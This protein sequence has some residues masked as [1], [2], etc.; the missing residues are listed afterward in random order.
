MRYLLFVLLVLTLLVRAR[1]QA[2]DAEKLFRAMEQKITQARAFQVAVVIETGRDTDRPGS[3]KGFLLLTRDN[4][5]RL[6]VSGA[7]FGEARV[8]QMVSNGKQMKL[9]PYD[10]GVSEVAKK[11]ATLPTPKD[12]HDHLARSVSRLGVFPHLPR[13]PVMLMSDDALQKLAVR[14]F[15]AGPAEKVGG[16]DA[17]VVRFK[18]GPAELKDQ[19]AITVW[20]D[21]KMLLPLKRVINL[22]PGWGGAITETYPTFTLDPRPDAGAFDPTFP[23]SEAEKLFRAMD[24]KIKRANAIRAAVRIEVKAGGKGAKGR[25]SLLFTKDNQ[26]RFQLEIDAPD[27]KEAAEMISDGKR[28]K[29]AKLPDPI[30]KAEADPVPAKFSGRLTRM[31]SSLGVLPVYED[32]NGA[33]PTFEGMHLVGFEAGGREKVGGRDAKVVS[34][35]LVGLPGTDWNVTLWIDAET[36]LPVKRVLVPIGGKPGHIT[37]TYE[38]TLNPKV[39]AKEFALPK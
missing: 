16:R 39:A 1:A 37:E 29:Y 9:R 32:V 3:F 20:I 24:Q 31:L 7:D 33:A 23:T 10:V 11:E 21:T 25:A 2:N 34:Y 28:L 27:M 19:A 22:G 15:K 14:D 4:K 6:Q 18:L 5:A 8:W 17:R 36:G 13:M 38:I 26:A 35:T 30:A 12:L